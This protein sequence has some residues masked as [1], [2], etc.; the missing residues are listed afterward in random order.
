ME[1]F[2]RST[3]MQ[4]AQARLGCRTAYALWWLG[5]L[6]LLTALGI[7]ACGGG[8]GNARDGGTTGGGGTPGGGGD[9]PGG[10]DSSTGL[11]G[12]YVGTNLHRCDAQ[13]L[14][15]LVTEEGRVADFHSVGARMDYGVGLA[16][17]GSIT[18]SGP[19]Y[20]ASVTEYR[21]GGPTLLTQVAVD[22]ADS[23]VEIVSITN[24]GF[25]VQWPGRQAEFCTETETTLLPSPNLYERSASLGK[26]AGVYSSASNAQSGYSVALSVDAN[27]QLSGSD[28]QGCV[29]NGSVTVPHTNRNYYQMTAT[30]DSCPSQGDYSGEALLA[31]SMNG[32]QDNLLLLELLHAGKGLAI[33]LAL[34]R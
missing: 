8:G 5:A 2:V 26:L 22:L 19:T 30:V 25:T 23:S 4:N 6:A 24:S 29:V 34:S 17:I 31:D 3:P 13:A 15:A 21:L 11:A 16:E 32:G 9:T 12:I 28:S 1:V 20:S 7:V 10:G 18:G 27:G 33:N 14:L